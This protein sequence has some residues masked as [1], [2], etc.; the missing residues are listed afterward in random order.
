M[1]LKLYCN[2]DTWVIQHYLD[3]DLLK[4]IK[5]FIQDNLDEFIE[6]T[7]GYSTT[8]IDSRQYWLINKKRNAFYEHPKFHEIM[9]EFTLKILNRIK[10]TGLFVK[11]GE[12]NI[13]LCPL[14]AWS[15]IGEEGSYHR[16]HDHGGD[17]H[18]I[19][20]LLYLEVPENNKESEPENS[21]YMI[22][23]VGPRSHM[24][25]NTSYSLEINPEVGKLLIFPNWI[26]HGT[27]PQTKGIRQTFNANFY[28][29]KE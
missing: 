13:K 17:I 27:Y 9:D 23:H 24:I 28:M 8:G 11:E 20:T 26:P 25:K 4:K 2:R 6:D 5:T 14:S 1:E 21:L 7:E 16:C 18:G 19:S 22:T 3:E 29:I 15:V 10:K 12:E